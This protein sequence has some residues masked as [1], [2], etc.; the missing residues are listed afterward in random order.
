M[1]VVF[2][3]VSLHILCIYDLLH[4]LLCYDK[5]MDPWNVCVY[6]YMCVCV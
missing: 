2:Y 5:L 6:V 1:F 4:I 3:T